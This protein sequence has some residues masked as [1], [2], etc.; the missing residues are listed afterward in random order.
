MDLSGETKIVGKWIVVKGKV[1]GDAN[2]KKI[3]KIMSSNILE[4]MAHTDGGWTTLY[5]DKTDGHYWE[6]TYLESHMHGGG[7][8]TLICISEEEV[9]RKFKI[10]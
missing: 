4:K 6:K 8:P 7:P 3:E 1:V 5:R 2:C 9:K 10:S